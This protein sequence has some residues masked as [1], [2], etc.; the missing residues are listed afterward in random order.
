M[1]RNM[2]FLALVIVVSIAALTT[3]LFRSPFQLP[4]QEFEERRSAR[5]R[6]FGSGKP[7]P[8]IEKGQEM[9]PRWN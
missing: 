8:P 9:R 1:S 5:E 6:F 3:A 2:I 4:S 7:L